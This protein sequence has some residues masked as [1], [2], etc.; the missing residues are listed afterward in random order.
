MFQ[1]KHG[2]THK[3]GMT[4]ISLMIADTLLQLAEVTSCVGISSR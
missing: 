4:I 3:L 2:T 1:K